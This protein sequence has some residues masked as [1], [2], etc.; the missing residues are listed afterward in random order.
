MASTRITVVLEVDHDPSVDVPARAGEF[1][2]QALSDVE[3]LA[4]VTVIRGETES[5]VWT[6]RQSRRA[7]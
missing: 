7:S 4:S 1:L 2:E 6:P 5:L 3:G